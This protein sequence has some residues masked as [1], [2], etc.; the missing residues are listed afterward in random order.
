MVEYRIHTANGEVRWVWSKGTGLRT[1][2]QVTALEG[3]VTDITERRRAMEERTRLQAQFLQ[4][5]KMESIGRLAGGVAH[6]FNNLLTVI[7][8]YSDMLLSDS[9]PPPQRA[10]LEQ[11]R[12]A[13]DRARTL[14]RQ[15]LAFSRKQV[16]ELR[17]INLN[18]V[19]SDFSDMLRRLIGEQILVQTVLDPEL[20][21]VNADASQV[22]QVIL[23]LAVNARDAMPRG[24]ILRSVRRSFRARHVAPG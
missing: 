16:L 15:L 3:F 9:P 5:Q 23:N 12:K 18:Q 13:G 20:G 2:D 4:A 8:G 22:V 7:L 14:T 24:G 6:D 1:G 21:W 10:D 17:R 11:I 19:V